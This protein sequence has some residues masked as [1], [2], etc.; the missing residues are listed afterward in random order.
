MRPDYPRV[1]LLTLLA[2]AVLLAGCAPAKSPTISSNAV[3]SAT[4]TSPTGVPTPVPAADLVPT[5]QLV[6][7]WDE[8]QFPGSIGIDV[9]VEFK[10]Q[11]K[12]W[13]QM[14][15]KVPYYLTFLDA[16]GAVTEEGPGWYGR[17]FPEFVGPGE[18]GYLL[19]ATS[20]RMNAKVTDYARVEVGL[21]PGSL[22]G[23]QMPDSVSC[24]CFNSVA[25]PGSTYEVSGITWRSDGSQP[26]LVAHGSIT[27]SGRGAIPYA[28]VA[29]LCIGADGSILG[30]TYQSSLVDVQPNQPN[31]F[32]TVIHTPPLKP[33]DCATSVG[34][35]GHGNQLGPME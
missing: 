33:S 11:G 29:V 3:P 35:L 6:F 20:S 4:T 13:A 17:P 34:L 23:V 18:K 1:R 22:P 14:T 31:A 25:P 32:E 5:Q 24:R 2:M 15:P 27:I 10:N 21:G 9:L 30:G 8:P 28:A 19:D 26:G 12:G 16:T 7:A